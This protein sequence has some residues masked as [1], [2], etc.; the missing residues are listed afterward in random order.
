[1][2]PKKDPVNLIFRGPLVNKSE[3]H[4]KRERKQF[5]CKKYRLQITDDHMERI[6]LQVSGNNK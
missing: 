2:D 1:M 5:F 4:Y 3:S 6:R